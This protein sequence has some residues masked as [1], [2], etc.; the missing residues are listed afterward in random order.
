MKIIFIDESDKQKGKGGKYFFV[1][2]GLI[3]D[4]E[5]LL[6]VE[7]RIELIKEKYGFKTLKELRKVDKSLKLAVTKVICEVLRKYD[8]T[9]ISSGIG[10]VSLRDMDNP[11]SKYKDALYFL[12]ERYWWYLRG[13]K[14]SGMVILD[15]V[16]KETEKSASKWFFEFVHNKEMSMYGEQKGNM[17]DR[18]HPALLFSNDVYTNILQVTD[19]IA[20]SLNAAIWNRVSAGESWSIEEL[21]SHNEF[22]EIYWPLFNSN[23]KRVDGYGLKWWS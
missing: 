8:A 17:I 2:C 19:L 7:R 6:E 5:C 13:H 1:L 21:P 9:I 4:S 10:R 18:V 12:A 16:D 11:T 3:I 15:S 22:L 23:G 20:L 14:T